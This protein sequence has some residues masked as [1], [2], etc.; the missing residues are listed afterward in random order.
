VPTRRPTC[1]L[2]CISTEYR[3][4]LAAYGVQIDAYARQ[5]VAV[6]TAG[7]PVNQS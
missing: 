7:S 5:R 1:A 3:I 6:D 4:R 2:Q